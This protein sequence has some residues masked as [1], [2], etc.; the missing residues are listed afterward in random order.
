MERVTRADM[1]TWA[2]VRR[3]ALLISAGAALGACASAP[4]HGSSGVPSRGA[5]DRWRPLLAGQSF[6]AWRGYQGAPVPPGWTIADGVLARRVS[7][8]DL[9]TRDEF[10]DFELEWEWKLGVGGDA[11]VFYR[12]TEGDPRIF[13]SAVEYQLEDDAHPLDGPSRLA[14]AGAVYGL[15]PVRP[16]VVRPAGE[17]NASRIVARGAHVEHWL[18]G[19]KVAEYEAGSADWDARVQGSKFSRW[20]NFGR[21]RRGHIAIQGDHAGEFAVRGMRIRELR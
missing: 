1:R 11:G 20:P 6:D 16:G 2:R 18:N 15:Y 3:V 8:G 19:E 14:A 12:G 17:W 13:F 10:G 4:P 21:A 7:T 9:V 5:A